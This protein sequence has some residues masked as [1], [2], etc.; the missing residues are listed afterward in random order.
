MAALIGWVALSASWSHAGWRGTLDVARDLGCL[1]ALAAFTLLGRT[2]GRARTM[3]IGLAAAALVVQLAGLGAWLA[4]DHVHGLPSAARVRL[5]AP[6]TYWNATGTIA[7]L[8]AVWCISLSAADPARAVRLA[9]AAGVAPAAATVYL[10]ASRGAALAALVGIAML[11]ATGPARRVLLALLPAGLG[12]GVALLAARSAHGLD[13]AAPDGG[14]LSDGHRSALLIAVAAVLAVAARAA[15]LPLERRMDAWTAPA[16]SRTLRAGGAVAALVVVLL[17]GVGVALHRADGEVSSALAPGA[18]F[19]E[20]GTNGRGDLWRVALREGA[21]AHPLRGSGAGT[22]GRL[23]ARDGTTHFD[24]VDAHSLY[25]ET[26]GELGLV[27]LVLLAAVLATL[28]I[29]LLRRAIAGAA[30]WAGLAAGA[31]ALLAHAGYDFDWEQAALTLPLFA[32]GGLALARADDD[33]AEAPP[34]GLPVL[35]CVAVVALAAALAL[36]PIAVQRSQRDLDA[37]FAA[38]RAGDCAGTVRHARDARGA[39]AQRPEPYEL[40]A[41]C[42]AQAGDAGALRLSAQAVARDPGD[43]RLRFSDALVRARLGRDPRPAFAAALA[44]SPAS[45]DLEHARPTLGRAHAPGWW[46]RA[47]AAVPWPE[48]RLAGQQLPAQTG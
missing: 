35:A 25:A 31:T 18:R 26:A 22:F 9:A 33:R 40:Q 34:P 37:A 36:V 15:V 27:G 45:L 28:L 1:G 30:A 14:A 39:L 3:L 5:S 16:V 12:A 23:W 11:L 42:A 20:I 47:A 44:R 17:G 32:V 2:D 46:R 21:K 29:A 43:W 13:V 10:T 24:A 38:S 19:Q 48:P 8:G 7:A 6:T 4:P 41:W